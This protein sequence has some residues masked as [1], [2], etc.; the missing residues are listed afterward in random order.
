MNRIEE[1]E[2][3]IH[4]LEALQARPES[5]L[6]P[7]ARAWEITEDNGDGTFDLAPAYDDSNTQPGLTLL[8]IKPLDSTV[9]YEVGDR[10]A[11]IKM[12]DGSKRFFGKG[13]PGTPPV[14][15]EVWS[16][17]PPAPILGEIWLRLT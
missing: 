10:V 13:G 6:P 12:G 4:E 11:V 8:N 1:L 9:E 5:L 16:E 3:R 15:L 17:D 2:R 7:M 14:Y